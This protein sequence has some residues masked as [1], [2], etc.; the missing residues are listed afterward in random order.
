MP[1]CDR[2]LPI[3]ATMVLLC[4]AAGVQAQEGEDED[5]LWEEDDPTVPLRET[6]R[7]MDPK[8]PCIVADTEVVPSIGGNTVR[9][10]L[11]TEGCDAGVVRD[12][13]GKAPVDQ[14]VYGRVLRAART[15][16]EEHGIENA[17]AVKIEFAAHG[18]HVTVD[19]VEYE[20][21]D[22]L[23]EQKMRTCTT[24]TPVDKGIVVRAPPDLLL[25][26]R[27][28]Q[29]P[30]ET[31]ALDQRS[32]E[33][34]IRGKLPAIL[35]CGH[36]WEEQVGVE[37]RGKCDVHFTITPHGKVVDVALVESPFDEMLNR[38]LIEKFEKLEFPASGDTIQI[39]WPI[40]F[41]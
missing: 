7:A 22:A 31:T 13:A 18:W 38:C 28:A 8:L 39:T 29:Q 37:P 1:S 35:Y 11:A 21:S 16:I 15:F 25:Q 27:A 12:D 32:I 26:W 10:V 5:V 14:G 2:V 33:R 41:D 3:V 17:T 4:G 40:K 24:W 20:A 30:T 36:S 23:P 9:V 19:L 34:V 6:L